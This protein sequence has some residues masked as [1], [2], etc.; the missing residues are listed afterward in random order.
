MSLFLSPMAKESF[1]LAEI[2]S[3]L[4]NSVKSNGCFAFTIPPKEIF[5]LSSNERLSDGEDSGKTDSCG[6]GFS[7]I[8][9]SVGNKDSSGDF[10][11]EIIGLLSIGVVS[12]IDS[13]GDSC[14]DSVVCN[15]SAGEDSIK[16]GCGVG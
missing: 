4:D 14:G 9:L 16:V 7:C 15:V 12:K 5:N 3:F 11:G 2:N 1:I 6:L 8:G 13:L 10:S